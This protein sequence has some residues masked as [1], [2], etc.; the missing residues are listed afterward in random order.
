MI[1]QTKQKLTYLDQIENKLCKENKISSF[2]IKS[3]LKQSS[4]EEPLRL[5]DAMKASGT[6]K[7]HEIK[8]LM[9]KNVY[10]DIPITINQ[11][12]TFCRKIKHA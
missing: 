7:L 11:F 2:K 9:D 4:M 10:L 8:G 3:L 6:G 5:R 1:L 12:E